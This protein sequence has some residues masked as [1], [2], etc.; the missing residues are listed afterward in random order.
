M[1]FFDS[2]FSGFNRR[3]NNPEITTQPEVRSGSTHVTQGNNLPQDAV[4][5]VPLSSST[6]ESTAR[7]I[8][9]QLSNIQDEIDEQAAAA[10]VQLGRNYHSE[11]NTTASSLLKRKKTRTEQDEIHESK[12]Q[13]I[14]SSE[15][16]QN[17]SV[18]FHNSAADD[19]ERKLSAK[20]IPSE[21]AR[22]QITAQQVHNNEVL[23]SDQR[24]QSTLTASGQV[25]ESVRYSREGMRLQ[26]SVMP[27]QGQTSRTLLQAEVPYTQSWQ[28]P[29][30]QQQFSISPPPQLPTSTPGYAYGIPVETINSSLSLQPDLRTGANTLQVQ[31]L[32]NMPYASMSN[33]F[34]S[35]IQQS[36]VLT[37]RDRLVLQSEQSRRNQ[38]MQGQMTRMITP[39]QVSETNYGQ[40]SGH[41]SQSLMNSTFQ[42][43]TTANVRGNQPHTFSPHASLTN[44]YQSSTPQKQR[45]TARKRPNGQGVQRTRSIETQ[46]RISKMPSDN[47]NPRA[48]TVTNSQS[49]RHSEIS[50]RL[51]TAQGHEV[52]R[53]VT[54]YDNSTISSR[55]GYRGEQSISSTSMKSDQSVHSRRS[56]LSTETTARTNTSTGLIRSSVPK[57]TGPLP[58]EFNGA[59]PVESQPIGFKMTTLP[60]S[61]GIGKVLIKERQPKAYPMPAEKF[62]MDSDHVQDLI[63]ARSVS[64]D[65]SDGTIK[66]NLS[67]NSSKQNGLEITSDT[68]DIVN[69]TG[70]NPKTLIHIFSHLEQWVHGQV[71][72]KFEKYKPGYVVRSDR[73]SVEVNLRDW[74]EQY[75]VDRLN[76]PSIDLPGLKYVP[77]K[78]AQGL[79]GTSESQDNF[80]LGDWQLSLDKADINHHLAIR[81]KK[82][83]DRDYTSSENISKFNLK[84]NATELPEEG[85]ASLYREMD[86]AESNIS[87]VLKETERYMA[88]LKQI[89]IDDQQSSISEKKSE[90]VNVSK[91]K[92]PRKPRSAETVSKK[93]IQQDKDLSIL[94]VLGNKVYKSSFEAV[95]SVEGFEW[96]D[97]VTFSRNGFCEMPPYNAEG[98]KILK[99]FGAGKDKIKASDYK[100]YEKSMEV[101]RK[102]S[103]YFVAKVLSS[104]LKNEA[105]LEES[106]VKGKIRNQQG[107]GF[108]ASPA[109]GAFLH[110]DIPQEK[111]T[112]IL[113]GLGSGTKQAPKNL[114][115]LLL[116]PESRG[117]VKYEYTGAD[118]ADNEGSVYYLPKART[119]LKE[120]DFFRSSTQDDPE[121][122]IWTRGILFCGGSK[123]NESQSLVVKPGI[124]TKTQMLPSVIHST[125]PKEFNSLASQTEGQEAETITPRTVFVIHFDV[126]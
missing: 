126:K 109:T 111:I 59:F 120:S 124:K 10:L 98:I 53:V 49:S 42:Q 118:G 117:K 112:V 88:C 90:A 52:P 85:M 50:T 99:K 43:P 74:I 25:L 44:T 17:P 5:N 15:S 11:E 51:L 48:T 56:Q 9:S 101:L 121:D 93:S 3:A 54:T 46:G 6:S 7:A 123:N 41:P 125:P 40:V 58:A 19:M 78:V 96:P 84:A 63:A 36:H 26:W 14:S 122:N 81:D 87:D 33:T 105:S 77:V 100:E 89:S 83:K 24:S 47:G 13:N 2:F 66:I 34:H 102:A 12:R 115:T 32:A 39:A 106:K 110:Q 116:K 30:L 72:E 75:E 45:L 91:L 108:R 20:S 57:A 8:N 62:F 4:L 79:G 37:T 107:Y 65:G 80:K 64:S 16:N 97:K 119:K 18:N 73:A 82:H 29:I 95:F 61:Q 69:D 92:S 76:D 113:P 60:G 28:I 68:Y 103:Y 38:Q 22:G 1:G 31:P 35:P 67:S 104:I 94:G 27:M 114:S 55:S 86:T 23:R 71:C 70:T 21:T